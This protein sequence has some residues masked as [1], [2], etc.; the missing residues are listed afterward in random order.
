[1]KLLKIM[2]GENTKSGSKPD[3]RIF[4]GSE[5]VVKVS[6]ENYKVEQDGLIWCKKIFRYLEKEQEERSE[7]IMRNKKGTSVTSGFTHMGSWH[8]F[9]EGL[10][11]TLLEACR[12]LRL[13]FSLV[14][15]VTWN[16][17]NLRYP[18]HLHSW[19]CLLVLGARQS[20]SGGGL[21]AKYEVVLPGAPGILWSF[22]NFF[23]W[24]Q[25][26]SVECGI[27][28]LHLRWFTCNTY[29]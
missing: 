28:Q 13:L 6:L 8:Y 15:I 26:N 22:L 17:R 23:Q 18:K 7:L 12:T 2:L 3:F 27:Y 9:R 1:M 10:V 11:L 21:D 29:F 5:A 20:F 16:L 24:R 14:S 25:C 19:N 4:K